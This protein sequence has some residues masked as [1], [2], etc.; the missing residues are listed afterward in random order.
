MDFQAS[1]QALWEGKAD[2]TRGQN[3]G[4]LPLLALGPFPLWVSPGHL[5]QES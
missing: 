5:H 3:S 2:K 1:T 4:T